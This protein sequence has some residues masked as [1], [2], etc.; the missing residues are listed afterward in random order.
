MK[1]PSALKFI[2]SDCIFTTSWYPNTEEE[3]ASGQPPGTSLGFGSH[4]SVW[5]QRSHWT[6]VLY[7]SEARLRDRDPFNGLLSCKASLIYL[8]YNFLLPLWFW[9]CTKPT[10]KSLDRRS[11]VFPSS[12]PQI[13]DGERICG[14]ELHLSEGDAD[15]RPFNN[16]R[17]SVLT[18]VQLRIHT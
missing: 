3:G 18:P 8:F 2:V 10:F 1:R 14:W 6:Y 15:L 7:L 11:S 5:L 4:Q 17:F 9:L 16:T 12:P 13:N